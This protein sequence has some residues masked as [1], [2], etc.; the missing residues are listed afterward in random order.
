ME[1]QLTKIL[2]SDKKHK[3]K[4][5]LITKK[6]SRDN[7][8]ITVLFDLLLNGSNVEKG[9]AAEVMKFVS[10]E[11]P[12]LLL[13]YIEILIQN[14]NSTI[15]RVKW[16]CPESIGYIARK[17]PKKVEEA[18]PNLFKNTTDKSIVVRWCAAFAL[19]EIARFN[20]NKQ[21]ELITRFK[22]IIKTESNNGVKNVYRNALTEIEKA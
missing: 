19:T 20:T 10:Q 8:L 2:T 22:K 16:G 1:N 4:V 6:I 9:T 17:Y 7:K 5:V 13:P 11:K 18:I 15:S 12:E 14:I 21:K 3:E